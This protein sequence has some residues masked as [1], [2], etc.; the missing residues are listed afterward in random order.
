MPL[1]SRAP[2]RWALIFG[3][4]TLVGGLV[5]GGAVARRAAA[6]TAIDA[7]A[8]ATT[9]VSCWLWALFTP[10]MFWL[11]RRVP[12][13]RATWAWAM[14]A[15]VAF[16]LAI[17]VLDVSADT[18]LR[19]LG[20][21]APDGTVQQLLA[22]E[23]FINVYSYFAVIACGHALAY[24]ALYQGRR[25][26][27][28]ELAQAL[29]Q[30]QLHALEL[31]LRPH[32]LFNALNTVSAQIRTGAGPDAIRTLSQLGDLLRALLQEGAH[33]V[34]VREELSLVDR[35]LS[36]EETRFG[37]RLQRSVDVDPRALEALVPRLILQPLVENAIRHGCEKKPGPAEVAIA[38]SVVDGMA[39]ARLRL[40]VRD[41]GP[42]LVGRSEGMGL[43]AGQ[44]AGQGIGLG[45]TR[46]RLQRLYGPDHALSLEAAPDGGTVA[47]VEIPLH[48]ERVA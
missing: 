18:A 41:T 45:N 35:Y 25:A 22:A 47:V 17:H 5:V 21:P 6:G 14:L 7:H 26:R 23:L 31:Q 37:G 44:G 46:E 11:A 29:A 8:L 2:I 12:I 42:G 20:V 43:G 36:I 13:T 27:E 28:A 30:S 4:W 9:F 32:F 15:H 34:T 19:A 39:G 40:T 38:A 33:E 1:R 16:A 10:L 24:Q 3:A 48:H